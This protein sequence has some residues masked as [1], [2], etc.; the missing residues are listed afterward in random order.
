M[1]RA[2]RGYARRAGLA[3]LCVVALWVIARATSRRLGGSGDGRG[4][5]GGSGAVDVVRE[6]GGSLALVDGRGDVR[7]TVR[8][9][10]C[11]PLGAYRVHAARG[12]V[13]LSAFGHDPRIVDELVHLARAI[14]PAPVDSICE[15]TPRWPRLLVHAVAAAVVLGLAAWAVRRGQIGV[16]IRWPHVI[17]VVIQ[18]SILAY[19]S[20][21]WSGVGVHLPSIVLQVA[22]ALALDAALSMARSGSWTAGFGPVPMV[23]SANLFAWFDPIGSIV[24]VGT[25]VATKTFVRRAGRHV[26]NPSAAGLLAGG[27]YLALVRSASWTGIFH[28]ENLAPN[29]VELIVA[30]SLFPLL[31]FR[32]SLVPLGATLGLLLAGSGPGVTTPGVIITFALF[33]SDPA[34]APRTQPG[35]F[36]YGVAIGLGVAV[37]SY[38]FRAIGAP[39]DFSKVVPV[40]AAN[41]ATPLFDLAGRRMTGVVA[42]ALGARWNPG[43]TLA[44]VALLVGIFVREKPQQFEAASH[45]TYGTPLVVRNDDDVPRCA[46]NP[47][48]CR[49]FAFATE[50]GLRVAQAGGTARSSPVP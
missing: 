19:W 2:A 40:V 16:E 14:E 4:R 29:I 37:S 24:V 33:A 44:W 41:L 1:T 21:Y 12:W 8:F 5:A 49:P 46:N 48:F 28:A 7:G 13:V 22:F 47:A 36:L 17:P 6:P 34:T 3:V 42:R 20:L 32:L 43:H 23:L 35:R 50:L 26:M 11:N 15:E 39:D 9:E 18:S 45:W 10:R 38:A 30:L 31:R 27:L 25:A